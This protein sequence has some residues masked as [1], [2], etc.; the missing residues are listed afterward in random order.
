MSRRFIRPIIASAKKDS[1]ERIAKQHNV[2]N[3]LSQESKIININD[4]SK[5]KIKKKNLIFYNTHTLCV[6]SEFPNLDEI[7][8]E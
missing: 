5:F 4:K 6:R 2:T 8:I 1:S 3:D 7:L